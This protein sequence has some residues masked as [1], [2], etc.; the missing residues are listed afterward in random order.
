MQQSISLIVAEYKFSSSTNHIKSFAFS[1]L[2]L[3]VMFLTQGWSAVS[4]NANALFCLLIGIAV[5]ILYFRYDWKNPYINMFLTLSYLIS[6]IM[7]LYIYGLPGSDYTIDGNVLSKGILFDLLVGL[8]PYIYGGFKLM[9]TGL[10]IH[11]W[12]ASHHL[13]KVASGQISF[14]S[15]G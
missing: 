10:L 5:I 9:L 14:W 4:V 15:V 11:V 3:F 13:C 7:E 12:W 6:V 8:L 2:F 1:S